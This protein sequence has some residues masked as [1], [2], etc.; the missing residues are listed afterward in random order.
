MNVLQKVDHSD[1]FVAP[2]KT[3]TLSATLRGVL[4][5]FTTYPYWDVSYLVAVIFTWGSVVWCINA[6]FVWLPLQ[7]PSTEFEGEIANGGGISA[8][9]GATIFELGSVLLMIEAVNEN[10]TE[11]FGWAFEEALG[12]RGVIRVRPGHC[13]HHHG[14]KHNLVGSGKDLTGK[15]IFRFSQID[16]G[17]LLVKFFSYL[18]LLNPSMIY[19]LR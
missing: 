18:K 12:E 8:F 9:I 7:D 16:L 19:L 14:N 3:N 5:M 11:C 10:R 1:K 13:T 15:V 2:P 17:I 6:F 4:R